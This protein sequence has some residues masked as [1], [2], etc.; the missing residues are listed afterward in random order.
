LYRTEPAEAK[1]RIPW[2]SMHEAAGAANAAE[3]GP[4]ANRG[5]IIRHW[6]AKLGGKPAKPWFAERGA[7]VRGQETS[8]IDLL[9]PPALKRLKENDFVDAVI[10]QV[11]VPQHAADYY[12]PNAALR[13]ALEKN[14]NTWRMIHREAVGND[15]DVRMAFDTIERSR[16]LLLHVHSDSAEFSLAGGLG[17][18]PV[19]IGGLRSYREP[20]LEIKAGEAW[21]PV[22][23]SVHG[24]DFWQTDFDAISGFWQITYSLPMDAPGDERVARTFRFRVK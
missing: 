8:L 4:R 21:N 13:A 2:F 15:V 17:Y 7:I 24:K 1:G 6:N 9:P 23:Q 12:G 16:P 18:V 14:Q 22:D 5:L 10:E 19:T 20:V 11:I 3:P